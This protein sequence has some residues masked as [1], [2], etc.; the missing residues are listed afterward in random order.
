M[1]KDVELH[2]MAALRA[3][4][5]LTEHF[6]VAA[7]ATALVASVV[8]S[9]MSILRLGND[10]IGS[11]VLV[12]RS[13]ELSTLEFVDSA[14]AACRRAGAQGSTFLCEGSLAAKILHED[15]ALMRWGV[16]GAD[17]AGEPNSAPRAS[18]TRM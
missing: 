15:L 3:K 5:T 14:A 7:C 8:A 4:W 9:Q 18:G 13:G 11:T 2:G 16:R 17:Q 1:E 10:T 12:W 6:T